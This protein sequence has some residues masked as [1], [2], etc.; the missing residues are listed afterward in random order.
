MFLSD[1][2]G[3]YDHSG[4]PDRSDITMNLNEIKECGIKYV[5]NSGYGEKTIDV[6]WKWFSCYKTGKCI[7]AN[8]RCDLRP[9]PDCIY[10]NEAGQMVAEDEEG[11]FKE[12]K[13][14][15]LVTKSPNFECQSAEHNSD[16]IEILLD[17]V[18]TSS[19]TEG[20]TE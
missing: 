18:E 4:C 16:T 15:G 20:K 7:H 19:Q 9:H 12:Y 2:W 13:S 6:S 8:S 10:K 3:L 11:C 14:K 1:G 5:D 17:L